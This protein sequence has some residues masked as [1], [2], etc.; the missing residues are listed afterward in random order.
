[1]RTTNPRVASEIGE[2]GSRSARR[3]RL[4]SF[5]ASLISVP[6]QQAGSAR[7]PVV[8][9]RPFALVIRKP[10]LRPETRT[11]VRAY[12]LRC[13]FC[14]PCALHWPELLTLLQ[15]AGSRSEMVQLGG[16]IREMVVGGEGGRSW[17]CQWDVVAVDASEMS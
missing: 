16:G 5:S 3:A 1:M 10:P 2:S 6:W 7:F 17:L 8:V 15:A 4:V 11:A 13:T 12:P 9:C 14:S